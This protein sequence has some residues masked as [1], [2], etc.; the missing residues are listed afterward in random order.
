[1]F[2][3]TTGLR[4]RWAASAKWA[5]LMPTAYCNGKKSIDDLKVPSCRL[6]AAGVTKQLK[7]YIESLL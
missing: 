7:S 5:P 1:M 2:T 3:V 4:S 6:A